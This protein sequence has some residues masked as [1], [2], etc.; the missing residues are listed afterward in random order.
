MYR[1][2][3]FSFMNR[4]SLLFFFLGLLQCQSPSSSSSTTPLNIPKLEAGFLVD[5]A[6]LGV[7]G[8]DKTLGKVWFVGGEQQAD[9]SIQS[10]IAYHEPTSVEPPAKGII[11]LDA[12]FDGGLLWWIWGDE[13]SDRLR[14]CGE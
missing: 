8:E 4:I 14:T 3:H 9:G 1:F 11:K 10:L 7:W 12:Q 2:A 13:S 6:L 5:G